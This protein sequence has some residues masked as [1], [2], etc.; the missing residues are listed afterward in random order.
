MSLPIILKTINLRITQKNV[1]MKFVLFFLI[2]TFVYGQETK[3]KCDLRIANDYWLE[4]FDKTNS[5]AEKIDL[6]KIKI[7][8]DS[9]FKTNNDPDLYCDY[10]AEFIL[11]YKKRKRLGLYLTNSKEASELIEKM[12][13]TNITSINLVKM[14]YWK[15]G[16]YCSN[17]APLPRVI[18]VIL[19]TESKALKKEIKNVLWLRK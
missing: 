1:N 8:S 11:N 16:L 13:S 5:L 3:K 7:K 18:L 4:K 9:I 2:C 19:K 15:R 17:P 6:I 12:D 14:P 10:K